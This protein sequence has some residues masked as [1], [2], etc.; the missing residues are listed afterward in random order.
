[1]IELYLYRQLHGFGSWQ[2]TLLRNGRKAR[3]WGRTI[4]KARA[5]A[6]DLLEALR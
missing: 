6:L 2:C 1:M 4:W 5:T 3:A